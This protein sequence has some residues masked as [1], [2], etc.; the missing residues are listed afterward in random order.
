MKK[1][2][3]S[4]RREHTLLLVC[5]RPDREYCEKREVIYQGPRGGNFTQGFTAQIL[6]RKNTGIK[7]SREQR[8]PRI[9][10]L[11]TLGDLEVGGGRQGRD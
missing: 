8:A 7:N 10:K 11:A 1:G 2:E 3:V 5:G 6:R 9:R 4:S